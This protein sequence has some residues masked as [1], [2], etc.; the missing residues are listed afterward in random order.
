M[1]Q[2]IIKLIVEESLE[3]FALKKEPRMVIYNGK[4]AELKLKKMGYKNTIK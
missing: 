4:N 3:H 1:K 2:K